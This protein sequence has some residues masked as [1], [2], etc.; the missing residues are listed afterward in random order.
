MKNFPK[1]LKRLSAEEDL[2]PEGADPATYLSDAEA[3]LADEIRLLAN[4]VKRSKKK[5]LTP[6]VLS[7][8]FYHACEVSAQANRSLRAR[9]VIAKEV[10]A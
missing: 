4:V 10:A 6:G 3:K 7:S 9:V 8:I 2:I 1:Y 5:G